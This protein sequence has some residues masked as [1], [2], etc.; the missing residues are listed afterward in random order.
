VQP[1]FLQLLSWSELR[2]M[3]VGSGVHD[4]ELLERMTTVTHEL[5]GTPTIKFFCKPHTML[6][7]NGQRV[8][9]VAVSDVILVCCCSFHAQGTCSRIALPPSSSASFSPSY[10]ASAPLLLLHMCAA[11]PS[12]GC[13]ADA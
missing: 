10:G 3:V 5:Q 12:M 11:V 7:W 13:W 9:D 2:M 6:G 1:A 4:T 8:C